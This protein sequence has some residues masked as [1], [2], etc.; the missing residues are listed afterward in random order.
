MSLA[1]PVLTV[2]AT[3][4]MSRYAASA[5]LAVSN[6]ADLSWH[7]C[8]LSFLRL[9]APL[10]GASSG[11][12]DCDLNVGALTARQR[13][14]RGRRSPGNGWS[15]HQSRGDC[16]QPQYRGLPVH[17]RSASRRRGHAIAKSQ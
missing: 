17:G 8:K 15:R 6:R 14:L 1:R 5:A 16:L 7:P 2:T 9:R 10:S 11:F 3:M 12:E 13:G 4:L